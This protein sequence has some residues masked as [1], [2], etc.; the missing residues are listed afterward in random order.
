VPAPDGGREN[1]E[2]GLLTIDVK[3]LDAVDRSGQVLD[4]RT[5]RNAARELSVGCAADPIGDE[6]Y[7]VR[8]A[9]IACG[10][11]VLRG[12]AFDVSEQEVDRRIT[13]PHELAIDLHADGAVV[14]DRK[15]RVNVAL[16][17]TRLPGSVN[18]DH[19]YLL[20]NHRTRS[21]PVAHP[22]TQSATPPDVLVEVLREFLPKVDGTTTIP[23]IATKIIVFCIPKPSLLYKNV[24]R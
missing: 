22:A 11:V 24:C 19:A 13:E 4:D 6:E 2:E 8:A 1:I 9:Q 23:R 17:E 10:D 3:I 16:D 20:L 5:Y 12:A 18:A 21:V 15:N 7:R 14:L